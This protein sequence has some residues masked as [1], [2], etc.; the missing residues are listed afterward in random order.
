MLSNLIGSYENFFPCARVRQPPFLIYHHHLV[1]LATLKKTSFI[2]LILN[3]MSNGI[4][5]GTE[6]LESRFGTYLLTL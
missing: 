3:T 5:N 2:L 4:V 1:E 6:G